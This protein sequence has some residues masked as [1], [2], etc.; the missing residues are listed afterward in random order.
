MQKPQISKVAGKGQRYRQMR[1]C[2]NPVNPV[3]TAV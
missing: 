3:F 1:N 2:F